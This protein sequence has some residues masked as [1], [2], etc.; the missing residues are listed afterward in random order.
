MFNN[1]GCEER[2]HNFV[3]AGER[4]PF[5]AVLGRTTNYICVRP[6][7]LNKVHVDSG[8]VLERE[9]EIPNERHG[10]EK[11]FGRRTADPRFRYTPPSSS[12]TS[13]QKVRKS[14]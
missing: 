10:F 6:V 2:E 13:E 9:S 8:E 11:D 3:V 12:E 1:G 7:V 5:A 4:E 14:W